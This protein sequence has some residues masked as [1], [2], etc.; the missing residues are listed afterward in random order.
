MQEDQAQSDL[1]QLKDAFAIYE[2]GKHRRYSLLFAVN[3]GAFAI[4]K[5]LA[6]EPGRQNA[7]LGNLSLMQLAIGMVIFTAVMVWDIHAFGEKIR[8]SYLPDAFGPQGKAVL[9]L[10]GALLCAGWLM[11]GVVR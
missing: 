10:L 8:K 5:L 11:V 3:G 2:N 9:F 7:V 4:A 6:A 1:L